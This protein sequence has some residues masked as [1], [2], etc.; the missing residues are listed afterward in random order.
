MKKIVLMLLSVVMVASLASCGDNEEPTPKSNNYMMLYRVIMAK[1][2]FNYG[3]PTL[4]VLNPV[5]NTTETI[6]LT[7]DMDNRNNTV[8]SLDYA[9]VKASIALSLTD[10][11]DLFVYYY[12]V[13]DI[14]RE[15]KFEAELN[16]SIDKDKTSLVDP[17]KKVKVT[18]PKVA[19]SFIETS[20][21]LVAIAP[22][23]LSTTT[24]SG[25]QSVEYY[26]KHQQTK[27]SGVVTW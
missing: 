3:N 2:T 18:S 25:E 15:M 1:N 10:P 14:K 19:A 9:V 7:E 26:T 22:V 21:A 17:V 12:P 23:S 20:G 5:K 27:A 8:Y 24:M 16:L 13:M 6:V 11:N 4:K